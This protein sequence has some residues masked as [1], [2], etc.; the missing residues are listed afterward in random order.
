M[1]FVITWCCKWLV[2]TRLDAE[3]RLTSNMILP[4]I[5]PPLVRLPG[6]CASQFLLLVLQL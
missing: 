5:K 3:G 1:A 6:R 4:L 2:D